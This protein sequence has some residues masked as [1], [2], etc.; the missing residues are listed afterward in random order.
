MARLY[1]DEDFSYPVIEELRGTRGNSRKISSSR[2][3]ILALC[4]PRSIRR[5]E[6]G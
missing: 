2:L 3:T 6:V 1:G 5:V 4:H